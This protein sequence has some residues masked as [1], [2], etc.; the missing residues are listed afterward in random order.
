MTLTVFGR[1]LLLTSC[2]ISSPHTWQR[3]EKVLIGQPDVC[4]EVRSRVTDVAFTD[5]SSMLCGGAMGAAK[6]L[7]AMMLWEIILCIHMMIDVRR[8]REENQR[9]ELEKRIRD[10]E[11]GARR[12]VLEERAKYRMAWHELIIGLHAVKAQK[13]TAEQRS[14]HMHAHIHTYTHAYEG[15]QKS[16]EIWYEIIKISGICTSTYSKVYIQLQL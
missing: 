7:F 6:Y 13:A 9:R 15:W 8:I 5:A 1:M 2:Q 3:T 16:V 12:V 11:E 4:Q 14:I 10:T